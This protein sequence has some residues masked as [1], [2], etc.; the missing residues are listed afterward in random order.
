MNQPSAHLP[1]G[2]EEV[3][4]AEYFFASWKSFSPIL[5]QQ[6][7]DPQQ[8]RP[9]Y[10]DHINKRTQ[11]TLPVAASSTSSPAVPENATNVSLPPPS[12]QYQQGRWQPAPMGTANPMGYSAPSNNQQ[13]AYPS[14]MGSQSQSQAPPQHFN[15]V[16]PVGSLGSVM[17]VQ[18]VPLSLVEPSWDQKQTGFGCNACG[19]EF[20]FINRRHRCR[21]CFR[22]YCGTCSSKTAPVTQ[23]GHVTPVRV[24][25]ACSGHLTTN[26]KRC[27][28]RLVP[29]FERDNVPDARK[30]EALS[31]AYDMMTSGMEIMEDA[32]ICGIFPPLFHVIETAGTEKA[33]LTTKALAIL[34]LLTSLDDTNC[35]L[36]VAVPGSIAKLVAV[37]NSRNAQARM[38]AAEIICALARTKETV[39]DIVAA[40]YIIP[41]VS[42]LSGQLGDSKLLDVCAETLESLVKASE[43]FRVQFQDMP[44]AV[45]NLLSGMNNASLATQRYLIQVLALLHPACVVRAHGA[46][47]LV[48]LLAS[49]QQPALR[50]LLS[51]MA[52]HDGAESLLDAGILRHLA[53]EEPD[54]MLAVVSLLEKEEHLPIVMAMF[55]VLSQRPEAGKELCE[56]GQLGRLTGLLQRHHLSED[57]KLMVLRV[58]A[59]LTLSEDAV[60]QIVDTGGLYDLV[61]HVAGSSV[62]LQTAYLSVLQGLFRHT[63][64]VLRST[65]AGAVQALTPLATTQSSSVIRQMALSCLDEMCAME[66]SDAPGLLVEVATPALIVSEFLRE[67]EGLKLAKKL[68]HDSTINTKL[69]QEGIFAT[70]LRIVRTGPTAEMATLAGSAL[71]LCIRQNSTV[72]PSYIVAIAQLMEANGPNVGAELLAAFSAQPVYRQIILQNGLIPPLVFLLQSSSPPAVLPHAV[73]AIANL[74]YDEN[75]SDVIL[76]EGG[77]SLLVALVRHPEDKVQGCAALALGNLARSTACRLAV[78]RERGPE[79]ILEKLSLE[80]NSPVVETYC[81]WALRTLVMERGVPETLGNMPCMRLIFPKLARHICQ[82]NPDSKTHALMFSNIMCGVPTFCEALSAYPSKQDLIV[83]LLIEPGPGREWALKEVVKIPVGMLVQAPSYRSALD[84]L[85]GSELIADKQAGLDLCFLTLSALPDNL[86]LIWI[87]RVAQLLPMS[88]RVIALVCSSAAGRAQVRDSG[89]IAP[90]VELMFQSDQNAVDAVL[91]LCQDPENAPVLVSSGVVTRFATSSDS[92]SLSALSHL[93]AYPLCLNV[94]RNVPEFIPSHLLPALGQ[95]PSSTPLLSILMALLRASQGS[96]DNYSRAGICETLLLS[97]PISETVVDALSLLPAEDLY[98]EGAFDRALVL[99]LNIDESVSVTTRNKALIILGKLSRLGSDRLANAP[100]LVAALLPFA[101]TR[102]ALNVLNVCLRRDSSV[103]LELN[104]VESVAKMASNTDLLAPAAQIFLTVALSGK[105]N[106]SASGELVSFCS[107]ILSADA[108]L[109][110]MQMLALQILREVFDMEELREAVEAVLASPKVVG[111]VRNVP[112]IRDMYELLFE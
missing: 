66:E 47:V 49:H 52:E 39:V 31:E 60:K 98:R 20:T 1:P 83:A 17:P 19:K 70:L 62:S 36:V 107:R 54:A 50:T 51:G 34:G 67:P 91:L 12:N 32:K 71:A 4:V 15:P 5:S 85:L 57:A 22:E 111:A 59:E 68:L 58:M 2:W 23:F 73:L 61:N 24:C 11:W 99:F 33:E 112:A 13:Y 10:V 77:V 6:K 102:V 64:A 63:Y 53:P 76:R 40:D 48:P 92:A 55:P 41:I 81:L 74:A 14:S 86:D 45:V 90:L 78:V 7:Y 96:D 46:P 79:I 35:A 109:G 42:V 93:V 103:F 94:L 56:S 97:E 75:A 95:S 101:G 87:E 72:D 80:G 28:S 106:A 88:S 105:V 89:A 37:V 26:R 82:D 104:G 29:Y 108:P 110:A 84:A 8:K 43:P 100:G 38:L 9:F 69:M 18:Q 30:Q 44:A 3:G 65:D 25:E 16:A 27:L 21:C